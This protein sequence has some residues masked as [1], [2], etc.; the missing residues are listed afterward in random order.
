[1][2]SP[3]CGDSKCNCIYFNF[4]RI[5]RVLKQRRHNL[6]KK[7]QQIYLS[8]NLNK[9]QTKQF[10]N[11]GTKPDNYIFVGQNGAIWSTYHLRPIMKQVQQVVGM[12]TPQAYPLYCIRIGAMSL[13]NQQ[14]MDL[15]KVLRFVAW[16]I[17]NLPHVSARYIN[18][19]SKELRTIPFEMIHGALEKNGSYIDRSSSTLKTFDLADAKG[20]LFE[21]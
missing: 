8:G 15:L 18:F 4:I 14:K 3:L 6:M 10:R 1:M 20:L 12:Q 11:L 9:T 21:K 17:N 7:L 19:Q 13:V 5:L 16:S 2:Q